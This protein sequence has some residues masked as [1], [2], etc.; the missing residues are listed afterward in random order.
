MELTMNDDFSIL[1][2]EDHQ[3]LQQTFAQ[4]FRRGGYNSVSC[5]QD[6][7]ALAILSQFPFDLVVLDLHPGS[8]HGLSLFFK[9]KKNYPLLPIILLSP[10]SENDIIPCFEDEKAW[11]IISKPFEPSFL[12]KSIQ[13][14]IGAST[15]RNAQ[16]LIVAC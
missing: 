4:I 8:D 10:N 16:P 14:I 9:I 13:A 2:I 6:L 5:N 3:P 7:T 12:L 1:I 15:K 11:M